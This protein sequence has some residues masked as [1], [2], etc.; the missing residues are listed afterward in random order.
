MS[1]VLYNTKSRNKELFTPVDPQRI[2]MYVCG[3]TVYNYAH[4][5]NARPEVIF[6]LL[7]RLLALQYPKV[8]FARNITDIDDKI[9]QAAAEQGIPITEISTRYANA[10]HQD[11]LALGAQ[12]PDIEPYATAHI[13]EIISMIE[14]LISS[15]HAYEAEGHVLFSIESF[16]DYGKL[17][18]RNLKDM[19]AGA[20]IEVAPFKRHPGDFVLWKPSLNPL[21]GWDSPWGWGRPGWHIECSAMAEKHLGKT[22]D[23]HGGGQDLV[24]PH[25]ENEIAQ[26]VC[27]HGGKAMAN[28]WLHNGFITVEKRKMSKSLG[29]TQTVHELLKHWQ[30]ETLRYLLLSAHYRQPQDWSDAEVSRCQKTLERLY[31]ILRSVKELGLQLKKAAV[32]PAEFLAALNDD[33]NTPKALAELNALARRIGN[34]DSPEDKQA[35][36]ADLLAAGALI[37]L[38]QHDP[39]TWLSAGSQDNNEVDTAAIQAMVEARD[40]ARAKHDFAEADRL[41]DALQAMG[42]KL[43]DS[44]TGTRWRL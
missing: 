37:G 7:R 33:L 38:L 36:A 27:A 25:H 29:N 16:A 10:Y 13:A 2:T 19:L 40:T 11:M 15:G 12:P 4:I 41:R 34:L 14:Q 39:A 18:G 1:I 21:P 42:I 20:R 28:Y 43:E 3:P 5:G 17:S 31:T 6:D 26:S 32:I 30:G 24:F 8:I 35:A 22:I 44:P 9:N 23:I